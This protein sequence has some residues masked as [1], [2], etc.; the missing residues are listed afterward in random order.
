MTIRQ[1]PENNEIR[2]LR[3]MVD[4]SEATVLEIG[5]GDGRLT[6]RYA[7]EAANVTAIDPFE[8]SIGRAK[9]NTP[10]NLRD[11]VKFDHVGFEDFAAQAHSDTFDLT[12]LP[13]AL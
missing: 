11:R 7:E 1:D 8:P 13:W 6:W 4:F 9:E 10:A 5:C 3:N 12:I 2:A